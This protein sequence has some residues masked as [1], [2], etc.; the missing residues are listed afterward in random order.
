[1]HICIGSSVDAR[2]SAYKNP[3]GNG[4]Q[5]QQTG[6]STNAP[7]TTENKVSFCTFLCDIWSLFDIWG[8]YS[9]V[10]ADNLTIPLNPGGNL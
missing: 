8:K 1:M 9:L 10:V 7:T 6:L 2:P 5:Q 4:T 3:T